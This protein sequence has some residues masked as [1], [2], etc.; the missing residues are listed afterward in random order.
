MDGVEAV[1]RKEHE[2]AFSRD[3]RDAVLLAELN[4][5]RANGSG[6]GGSV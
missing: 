3:N 5:F 4:R 2:W 6:A 1:M